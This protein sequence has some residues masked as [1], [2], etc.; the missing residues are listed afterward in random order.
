MDTKGLSGKNMKILKFY[1]KKY[2]PY[3]IFLKIIIFSSYNILLIKKI[4]TKYKFFSQKKYMRL[5]E[6][7]IMCCSFNINNNLVMS[8]EFNDFCKRINLI[9]NETKNL[10]RVIFK[11][12]DMLN[13][14]LLK[15][16]ITN[17]LK[18]VCEWYN[19]NHKIYS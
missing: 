3:R 8:P 4:N 12:K 13:E 15:V 5:H 19:V 11:S 14:N 2:I 10:K 7:G 18:K 9:I 17:S 16:L 1:F 6:N